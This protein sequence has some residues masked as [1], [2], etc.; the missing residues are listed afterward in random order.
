MT[1]HWGVSRD[2]EVEMFDWM[3]GLSVWVAVAVGAVFGARLLDHGSWATTHLARA[4]SPT[5]TPSAT[6]R[7]ARYHP[8]HDEGAPGRGPAL[9]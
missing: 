8:S 3:V 5:E 7:D 6:R 1:Q 4:R 9:G 2:Q